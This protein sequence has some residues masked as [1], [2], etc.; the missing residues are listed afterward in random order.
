[1]QDAGVAPTDDG[2]TIIA[3][4]NKDL[5]QDGPAL[6]GDPD[7][8]FSGMA[9]FG[10][11]L[12]HHVKLKVRTGLAFDDII[13]VDSPG[14]IDSPTDSISYVGAGRGRKDRGYDFEGVARWMAEKADVILLFFDPDKPGTTGE[15]LS[16]LTNALAGMDYK[17]VICLNKVDVFERTSDFAR[18]YGALT[19]NLS[20][21]IPRKDLPRIY[22]TCTP[23]NTPFTS[24]DGKM[25]SLATRTSNG[26]PAQAELDA[27]RN[28]VTAA[29]RSAPARRLDNMITNLDAQCRLLKMH[30]EI[31]DDVRQEYQRERLKA[32][33]AVTGVGALSGLF[34]ALGVVLPEAMAFAASLAVASGMGAFGLSLYNNTQLQKFA[35]GLQEPERLDAHFR[36][37]FARQLIEKDEGLVAVWSRVR[38]T[39]QN[40]LQL[41]VAK[42]P[43]L[44]S[45][46]VRELDRILNNEIPALR[47]RA[48]ASRK[49]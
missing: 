46:D 12:V 28:E 20:K 40:A 10:P 44:S 32:M 39:V 15:T 14:M 22:T 25:G 30:V 3:P 5:D 49:A 16:V 45:S 35:K 19:W 27:A 36:R 34:V 29:I 9:A 38:P 41:G 48:Q 11:S 13:L 17:L 33:G 2:F 6:V 37:R 1:M 7:Y 21:V 18:T 31:L 24:P 26:G 43:K 8:G 4:G 42:L 47:R 23:L